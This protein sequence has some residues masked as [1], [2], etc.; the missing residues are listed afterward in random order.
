M[1]EKAAP[2]DPFVWRTR[3]FFDDLDPMGLLH[4][5]RYAV[6]IERAEASLN[7]AQGRRW[8]SD[9]S[10]NPDQFYVVREQSF[11]FTSPIRGTCEAEVHM[12]LARLGRTSL[13]W[14]F[15][16]RT[17][18]EIHAVARRTLVKLDPA[19][20]LP[21]SWSDRIRED[22]ARLAAPGRHGAP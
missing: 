2:T 21:A 3:I 6:L 9:V 4:N 1:T 5:S 20:L 18:R 17:A 15:E 12:W 14:E 19:T 13:T 16:I 8:E 7:L 22:Y 10:K 11:V